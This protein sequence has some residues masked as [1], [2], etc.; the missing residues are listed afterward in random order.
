MSEPKTQL[1]QCFDKGL[2]FGDPAQIR[3]LQSIRREFEDEEEMLELGMKK[4]RVHVHVEGSYEQDVWA[5]CEKDAIAEVKDVFDIDYC[6]VDVEYN[7][8]EL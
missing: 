6:D 7:G 1:P 2:Q 3:H 4:Y 5:T 8:E